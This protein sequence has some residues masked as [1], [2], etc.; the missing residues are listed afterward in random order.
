M[1]FPQND[2][3]YQ[4]SEKILQTLRALFLAAFMDRVKALQMPTC[5]QFYVT[6]A[7]YQYRNNDS[8]S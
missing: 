6:L 4:I 3:V 5:S 7:H 8:C 2:V 1:F